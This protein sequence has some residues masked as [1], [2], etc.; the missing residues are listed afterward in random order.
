[1]SNKDIK[2]VQLPDEPGKI[3]IITPVASPDAGKG[4]H[5]AYIKSCIIKLRHILHY[6]H[7]SFKLCSS[8]VWGFPGSS[9]VKNATANA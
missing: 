3:R 9:V 8:T 5:C 4:I 7:L 6:L 1:M 2:L